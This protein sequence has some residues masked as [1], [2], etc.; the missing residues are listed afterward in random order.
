MSVPP[1]KPLRWHQEGQWH[2]LKIYSSSAHIYLSPESERAPVWHSDGAER[3]RAIKSQSC[4]KQRHFDGKTD[5]NISQWH[6]GYFW[7]M[8]H[9]AIY[10]FSSCQPY[11]MAFRVMSSAIS[12]RPN[13]FKGQLACQLSAQHHHP[14]H[15]KEDEVTSCLQNGI[16]VELFQVFCLRIESEIKECPYTRLSL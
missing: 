12:H 14:G 16:G 7:Y 10:I 9:T 2:F 3:E 1:K 13:L 15:P 8:T 6:F 5:G 4:T 11:D